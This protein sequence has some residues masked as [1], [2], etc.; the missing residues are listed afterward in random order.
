MLFVVFQKAIHLWEGIMNIST[1]NQ[2]ITP[3]NYFFPTCKNESEKEKD[4]NPD[5]K[6]INLN[7]PSTGKRR[8]TIFQTVLF[9]YGSSIKSFYNSG[10]LKNFCLVLTITL[11]AILL[12]YFYPKSTL[13][14]GL[15]A[16][17]PAQCATPEEDRILRPKQKKGKKITGLMGTPYK[18]RL[19]TASGQHQ[20]ALT[21]CESIGAPSSA[22]HDFIFYDLDGGKLEDG[23]KIAIVG[24]HG[25]LVGVT[26]NKQLRA[27]RFDVNEDT[28][29]II[30]RLKVIEDISR[31]GIFTELKTY[32]SAVDKGGD[33]I[34]AAA[35]QLG[36][37]ETFSIMDLDDIS[38]EMS[39]KGFQKGVKSV[40][41]LVAKAVMEK[42]FGKPVAD[43]SEVKVLP[44]AC[45]TELA[46][47]KVSKD[48]QK[49]AKSEPK[50]PEQ[51][52]SKFKKIMSWVWDKIDKARACETISF[53]LQIPGT[54]LGAEMFY[55]REDKKS[56]PVW[57]VA[58]MAGDKTLNENPLINAIP[59]LKNLV[60]DPKLKSLVMVF[61]EEKGI[62]DV[63][64]LSAP[65]R[66][67]LKDHHEEIE[68]PEIFEDTSHDLQKVRFDQGVN[69]FAEVE[70]AKKGVLG[71]V[72]NLVLPNATQSNEPWRIDGVIGGAF[73]WK[74]LNKESSKYKKDLPIAYKDKNQFKIDLWIPGHTPYPFNFLNQRN[75]F[76]T[77]VVK[78]RFE[79]RVSKDKQATKGEQPE[80]TEYGL[81]L[82]IESWN[83][84]W[85][86][87]KRFP[88][89]VESPIHI[90][91][92]DIEVY[93]KGVY[94]PKKHEDPLAFIPGFHVR[95]L[96]FGGGFAKKEIPKKTKDTSKKS[97][98]SFQV[99]SQVGI[100]GYQEVATGFQIDLAAQ[101][102]KVSLDDIRLQIQGDEDEGR[103]LLDKLP[104]LKSIPLINEWVLEKGTLGFKP[105][106]GIPDF[107]ITGGATWTR[108]NMGSKIA[109]MKKKLN[110]KDEF[111]LFSRAND[112]S[113]AGLLPAKTPDAV[114]GIFTALKMPRMLLLLTTAKGK[115]KNE[116]GALS[117]EDMP[118]PL[119]PL[120][121]GIVKE[122]DES[123]PVFGDG[124]TLVSALDFSQAEDKLMKKT[125]STLGLDKLGTNG[126][127]MIAGSVGGLLNGELRIGLAAKLPT[128]ELPTTLPGGFKNPLGYL[129][130]FDKVASD[131][132]LDF[133]ALP[134]PGVELGVSGDLWLN[135]PK[136]GTHASADTTDKL[137]LDGRV[138]LVA[139]AAGD[140]GF[141][142]NGSMRGRWNT[143]L[144]L[145]NLALENTAFIAGMDVGGPR[146]EVGMGGTM[147]VN[148]PGKSEK[149]FGADA[150]LSLTTSVPPIPTKLG[151]RYTAGEISA[152]TNM[153][154]QHALF[155]G[156]LTG[157]LAQT[158]VK[159]I[160]GEKVRNA[161]KQLGEQ[162]NKR[163]LVQILQLDKIPLPLLKL[164]DVDVYFG[165][166]GAKIPGRGDKGVP[167]LGFRLAAQAWLELLGKEHKLAAADLTL[168]VKDGFR[169]YG[170]LP[171]LEV[172]PLL[173]G[174]SILDIK[175]SF[176]DIPHFKMK[177][178]VKLD[179]LLDDETDVELSKERIAFYFHKKFGSLFDFE[180]DAHTEGENVLSSKEFQL[181]M[182]LE[183]NIDTFINDKV[184]PKLGVPKP[185]INALKMT[186][187]LIIRKYQVH[188]DMVGFVGGKTPLDVYLEPRYFG[189][190]VEPVTAKIRGPN[191]KHPET[192]LFLGNEFTGAMAGSFLQYLMNNPKQTAAF[193]I[194]PS[195]LEFKPGYLGGAWK[196]KSNKDATCRS[197]I[198]TSNKILFCRQ[199]LKLL[200][201]SS[202]APHLCGSL[203]PKQNEALSHRAEKVF[204]VSG[205]MKLPATSPEVKMTFSKEKFGHEIKHKMDLQF[206]D[207]LLDGLIVSDYHVVGTLTNGKPKNLSLKGV[208]SGDLNQ[209]FQGQVIKILGKNPTTNFL[210]K[211]IKKLD[212]VTVEKGTIEGKFKDFF[213][214]NQ[215]AD[216]T[217]TIR[218]LG[219]YRG[220]AKKDQVKYLK[221]TVPIYA[222][223][224]NPAINVANA[225]K[226]ALGATK[227]IA[228]VIAILVSDAAN[229]FA[230][231]IDKF[232]GGGR[233]SPYWFLMQA[234]HSKLCLTPAGGKL[235][236][237][238]QLVEVECNPNQKAQLWKY[239][240]KALG[241]VK[242]Y[243][244]AA[245]KCMDVAKTFVWPIW[246]YSLHN[247]VKVQISDCASDAN[248]AALNQRF[249]VKWQNR[250]QQIA[251]FIPASAVLH[252]VDVSPSEHYVHQWRCHKNKD[253]QFK[254]IPVEKN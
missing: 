116:T 216:L 225:A 114:K 227:I 121:D 128:F 109:I 42:L 129:V 149:E 74:L 89:K 135:L 102:K 207:N 5:S 110:G 141:R 224:L 183:Q 251:K 189:D 179:P 240:V 112:F 201:K 38:L 235:T 98:L 182:R 103:I 237:G 213:F 131:F 62:K 76:H 143:P 73:M 146:I 252:C 222:L 122:A 113:L 123:I 150:I 30:K 226:T 199:K 85:L 16:I 175:A 82:E 158:V 202:E 231:G 163:S 14:A 167:G 133:K 127:I 212:L 19:G 79:I 15:K 52:K 111:F 229:V 28:T 242:L 31:I 40:G 56:V 187:P 51:K 221:T 69:L 101:G 166:P 236:K 156:A 134:E 4:Q 23:N 96:V 99:G 203:L 250:N 147:Y 2:I 65:L 108:T 45:A 194:L 254:L 211:E 90:K 49:E 138:Y 157:P 6:R 87:G 32:F 124:I 81:D 190:D 210:I 48:T 115:D 132:Y 63:T 10:F 75:A 219:K 136:L 57:H 165:T 26:K 239:Q 9:R 21:G 148:L 41:G 223:N 37:E 35:T 84:Y 92:D 249:W 173:L 200:G 209:W 186:N 13:A 177:G 118:K 206:Q 34:I 27:D 208:V 171:K 25:W 106:A 176:S 218:V 54:D 95:K 162:L 77:E 107:Y 151:F 68:I 83:E 198:Q 78:A 39:V 164:K 193:K 67:Y 58:L 60:G 188:G 244:Q 93:L 29:F 215:S 7:F 17:D 238:T 11:S 46:K 253:Q 241:A 160:P 1:S 53:A 185:I 126:T 61:S 204:F 125:L 145:G 80:K 191:W 180:F 97:I 139:N 130:E 105:T 196:C 91:K 72:T 220:T 140:S 214:K 217:L 232:L 195:L 119:V 8:K 64:D 18:V 44:E 159:A 178:H 3:S 245:N 24:P 66:K 144:G 12:D 88:I 205:G 20:L 184:L 230:G 197:L 70:S 117:I 168:S 137:L 55:T 94:E 100:E 36:P 233:E 120:F 243:N 43:K 192:V 246:Y 154:I 153:E 248:L 228:Q 161:A 174:P 50:T 152:L 86:L 181:T 170:E 155:V 47:Q 142:V 33:A 22:G 234:Q 59:K 104:V 172:K 71:K 169:V 247:G